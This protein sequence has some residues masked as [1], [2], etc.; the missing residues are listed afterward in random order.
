M[1]QDIQDEVEVVSR[2]FDF[3]GGRIYRCRG[4]GLQSKKL[5]NGDELREWFFNH[6]CIIDGLRDEAE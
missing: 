2:V 4:C 5:L 1:N 3:T 6:I